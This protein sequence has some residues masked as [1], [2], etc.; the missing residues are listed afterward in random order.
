LVE[1]FIGYQIGDASITSKP[2]NAPKVVVIEEN[3]EPNIG[4]TIVGIEKKHDPPIPL[5]L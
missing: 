4:P 5:G 1:V 2:I 3:Q